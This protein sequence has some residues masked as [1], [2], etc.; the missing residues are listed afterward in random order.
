MNPPNATRPLV[1]VIIPA[2]NHEQYVEEAIRSVLGQTYPNVEIVVVDDASTDGTAEIVQGLAD[3]HRFTFI[4]NARN[5]GINRTL[6]VAL[7]RSR[8]DYLSVL[9]SDD[10]IFPHKVGMQVD[11]LRHTG[12]DAVYANAQLLN[13]DGSRTGVDLGDVADRFKR[14]TILAHVYCDDSRLPL[15]QSALIRRTVFVELAPLRQKFKSDD[16]VM[17]IKLLERFDVGFIAEPLFVYRQHP[18]NSFKNY[19]QTLP[20]RVEVIANAVPEK[21]RAEAL[22]RLLSSQAQYLKWDGQHLDWLH[23]LAASIALHPSPSRFPA[24]I[25]RRGRAAVAKVRRML[26]IRDAL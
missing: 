17:L 13:L 23:Y 8:G 24:Y 22:A 18:G 16:W 10:M 1:S 5:L 2:F 26:R 21:Y 12:K 6:E 25:A 4:R 11:Y 15:L 20:A 9:A 14:G 7:E 19:W 3:Q